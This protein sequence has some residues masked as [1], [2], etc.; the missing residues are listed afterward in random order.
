MGLPHM[1]SSIV[2][3]VRGTVRLKTG[4]HGDGPVSPA[5]GQCRIREMHPIS[6]V[7]STSLR[8]SDLLLT[9][10]SSL[11]YIRPWEPQVCAT[12]FTLYPAHVR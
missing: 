9:S 5:I 8:L 10:F 1:A 12:S 3:T 2:E 4:H 7:A 6:S 11:A